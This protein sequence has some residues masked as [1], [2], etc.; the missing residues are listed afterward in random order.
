MVPPHDMKTREEWS[1]LDDARTVLWREYEFAPGAYATT[2]VIRGDEGLI[3]VSPA[4]GLD[5]RAFD[6]LAEHGPVRALVA[7]NPDHDMGQRAWRTRFP[8]AE[9]FCPPGALR[10]LSSRAP[11]LGYKPLTALALPRAVRCHDAPG[12]KTAESLWC[13]D[14]A[15]GAVWYA[16]DL[17]ANIERMPGPPIRWL[18]TLSGSAPGFRLFRLAV[19]RAVRDR[20]ALRAW[21]LARFEEHPPAVVVPGHGPPLRAPDVA[22]RARDAIRGL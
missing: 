7:N 4:A 3:V 15:L 20:P 1:A 13:V 21:A 19:W 5:A 11:E 10:P 9:S 6:A 17:L 14:T 18:F 12:F 22:E 8:D 2:M 16:G